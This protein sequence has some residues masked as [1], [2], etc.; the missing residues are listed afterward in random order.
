MKR[1]TTTDHR[2]Y[3]VKEAKPYLA[4]GGD[5]YFEAIMQNDWIAWHIRI[6]MPDGT[7]ARMCAKKTG[8]PR[9][10]TK[11]GYIYTDLM[12]LRPKALKLE[13]TTPELTQVKAFQIARRKIVN[14][15][16][17]K[18]SIPVAKMCKQLDVTLASFINIM[19]GERRKPQIEAQICETLG[20]DKDTT[21]PESITEFLG[22]E[23]QAPT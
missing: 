22:I 23:Y 4:A 8:L 16:L 20:L 9:A 7:I 14:D 19:L 15:A 21:F 13:L 3:A 11:P 2:F 6:N 10:Y 12:E 5:I 17:A 1:R 18:A